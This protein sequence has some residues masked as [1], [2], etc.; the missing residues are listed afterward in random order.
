MI[1]LV[2]EQR[3][4][5]I[6]YSEFAFKVDRHSAQCPPTTTTIYCAAPLP[7]A[8][9]SAAP[10]LRTSALVDIVLLLCVSRHLP[11]LV[12]RLYLEK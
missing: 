12:A 7:S 2:G 9:D 1:L 10:I 4:L 11:G 3:L 8:V 6:T 5:T